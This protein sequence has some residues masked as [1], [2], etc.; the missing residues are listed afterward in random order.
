MAHPGKICVLSDSHAASLKR[1]W[2][3]IKA[4]FSGTELTFFAGTSGEW[5][6]LRAVDGKLVPESAVLREQFARSVHRKA[7]IADEYDA[8]IICSIGL[9]I[10]SALKTWVRQDP[11]DWAMHRAIV[12]AHIQ[13]TNCAHVMA[14][15]REITTKPVLLILGP[16]QPKKF[17]LFSPSIASEDAAAIRRIFFEECGAL[18]AK[19]GAMFIPQPET[20]WAPNGVTT[21]M[22]FANPEPLNGQEDRRHCTP[23][24]GAIVLRDVLEKFPPR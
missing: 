11:K 22:K 12:A 20:T 15:L 16:F 8:Y 6:S 1:G 13:H 5:N 2:T 7:E 9:A 23:E 21:K 10:S 17:C 14:T 3:I 18:A 24:Y 4:D 19:H